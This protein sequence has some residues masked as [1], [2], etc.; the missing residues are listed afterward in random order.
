[1]VPDPEVDAVFVGEVFC[2]LV[3]GGTP[4][5][6][7]PGGEVFAEEFKVSA[8]GTATR[9]V[10]AARLGLRTGVV[11]TVGRDMFGD[12]VA[13]E[14]AAQPGL[15]LR[16]L[17]RDPGVH[18]P[19]TVA[20]ANREDRSFITYEEDG[21]R[22]PEHW[23]GP[24]PRARVTHIG[25]RRPLPEWVA[26]MRAAGT[27]VIGGI[28]WD[29]TGEWSPEL[30]DR[31]TGVDMF[32]PNAVE[33]MRYTRTSSPEAAAEALAERV[34]EVVVTDGPHGAVGTDRATGRVIRVPAPRV[35]AADPTGAG[36]VFTSGYV[37]GLLASWP[38]ADRMRFAALCAT[39]SVR[40]LG[41]A[42]SAP[43]FD[44]LRAFLGSGPQI[45]G[46][47][48]QLIGAATARTTSQERA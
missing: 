1:V 15:D 14:L 32:V 5:L 20:V 13:A 17:R 43:T 7:A 27:F 19:V 40:T 25:M 23:E 12:R 38:L 47:D 33:A 28:G 31:L 35:E 24:L 44:T 3:F 18:T 10:A 4:G 29:P 34:P 41:G 22:Y 21:A 16:W 30:L 2:D 42:D 46:R 26:R 6:P 9:C 45:T 8:G 37:Y 11:A 36:D 39:S 48:H